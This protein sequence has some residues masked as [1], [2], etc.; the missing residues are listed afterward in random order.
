MP[1]DRGFEI[2]KEAELVEF[3]GREPVERS[4]EDG[5]WSFAVTDKRG[6]KL[7]FSFN[8]HERSVQTMLSVGEA[9]IETVSHE[10][11]ARLQIK[12]TQLQTTFNGSDTKTL[13]VV[14]IT[15]SIKIAWSTLQTQ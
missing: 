7:R 11:A 14:E 1:T 8:L 3:F 9:V 15:P 13:L 6:V 5:F 2:P 10:L 4:V 12:G